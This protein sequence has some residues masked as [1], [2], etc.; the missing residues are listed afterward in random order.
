MQSQNSRRLRLKM[1]QYLGQV[2]AQLWFNAGTPS[3]RL[4]SQEVL[5]LKS[6]FFLVPVDGN[7]DNVYRNS[8]TEISSV[9]EPGLIATCA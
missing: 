5:H 9:V 4:H 1:L 2:A 6:I 3:L 7:S 8:L